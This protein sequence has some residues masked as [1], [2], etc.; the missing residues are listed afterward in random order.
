MLFLT[1]SW[2]LPVEQVPGK[3]IKREKKLYLKV[4]STTKMW[5]RAKHV[6]IVAQP[7]HILCEFK[8]SGT[9]ECSVN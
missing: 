2:Y 6:S 5:P 7:L 3:T 9:S 4:K 1:L 8:G